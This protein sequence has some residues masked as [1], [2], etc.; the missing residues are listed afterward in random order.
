[1]RN[2]SPRCTWSVRMV[3]PLLLT[4]RQNSVLSNLKTFLSK[5][6]CIKSS[7]EGNGW[8]CVKDWV[9]TLTIAG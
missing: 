1:M 8:Y 9:I 4:V 2:F 5:A 7:K 6:L 3:L